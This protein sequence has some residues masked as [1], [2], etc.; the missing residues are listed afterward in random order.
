MA[1]GPGRITLWGVEV[2][3][4]TAEEAS[5]SAAARRLGSSP[6][7]VSQQITNLEGVLGTV[8][9]D[10]STRPISPTAAGQLFLRRANAILNE[11]ALARAELASADYT[12]MTRLRLGIVEDFDAEVTPRL[13]AGMAETMP[14]CQFLLETGAS[15]RLLDL[16]DQRALDIAVV[17]EGGALPDWVEVHPLLAEPFIAAVPKGAGSEM[18][19]D[20]PLISYTTRHLMGRQIAA[21][22]KSQQL[23]FSHRFELDSYHAILAMVAEGTGW[24]IL[25]PLGWLRA[26]RFRDKVDVM[27]L[28]FGTL[29]R[30]ISLMARKDLLGSVPGWVSGDL[31][32]QIADA[33][34]APT[35]QEMPWLRD[36]MRVL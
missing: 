4:A 7:T 34:V 32:S 28:P 13:L 6:A 23:N 30:R 10:R 2:F 26:S 25:T 16:L 20:M 29:S 33:I 36:T 5:I 22:L 35:T 19:R 21:H 24:S 12:R 8:L 18:L 3:V 14:D 15:H 27:P 11:A 9:L 17:A 1:D 31:R